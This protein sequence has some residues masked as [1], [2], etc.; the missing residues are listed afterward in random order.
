MGGDESS[1]VFHDFLGISYGGGSSPAARWAKGTGIRTLLGEASASASASVG[2]SSSGHRL[3]SGSVDLGSEMQG[4]S[5]SEVSQHDGAEIA[6]SGLEVG[7][8][9]GR[10]R[11]HLD[12]SYMGTMK[13]VVLPMGSGSLE[14]SYATKMLGKEVINEQLG[15]ANDVEMM[16]SMQPPI[17]PTK[18]IVHQT[19]N[20][21]MYLDNIPSYACKY[22]P[23]GGAII[24][25][26]AADEGSR[27]GIRGS[28]VMN[29]LGHNR[30]SQATDSKSYHVP[31]NRAT[32]CISRQMTIFYAG[33]AHVF[34]DVHP[35]KADVIMA[36]AGSSGGSW[37]T[38]Y[39]TA[40]NKAKVLGRDDTQKA[41]VPPSNGR[42]RNHLLGQ[43]TQT[44]VADPLSGHI[45]ADHRGGVAAG[46]ASLMTRVTEPNTE[47]KWMS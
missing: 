25:Q 44:P 13:D 2:V 36:L 47:G 7:N 27:T 26:S 42:D 15:R 19:S 41:N 39:S 6:P 5:N 17:R 33:Q 23:S 21:G 3:I 8:T 16:S 22:F 18:Q 4:V 32:A 30:S 9:S 38:T 12:S 24:S 43:V 34:D 10:K 20:Y 40:M 29:V 45:S 28:G 31:R 14:S 37:S 46:D 1:P 11:N 35:N